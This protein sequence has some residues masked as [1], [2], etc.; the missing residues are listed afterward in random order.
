MF[1]NSASLSFLVWPPVIAL[2]SL[3]LIY[4]NRATDEHHG[5]LTVSVGN[6]LR[7]CP[8]CGRIVVIAANEAMVTADHRVMGRICRRLAK[9]SAAGVS[10]SDAHVPDLDASGNCRDRS[11]VGVVFPVNVAN[12]TDQTGHASALPDRAKGD[13]CV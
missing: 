9:T 12:E 6:P 10:K 11:F 2:R 7:L 1:C 8:A 4:A 13:M 3:I 5:V